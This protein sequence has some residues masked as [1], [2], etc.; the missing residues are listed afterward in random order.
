M[1]HTAIKIE[2]VSKLYRL[3]VY[4]ARTLREDFQRWWWKVKGKGDPLAKIDAT[5]TLESTDNKSYV[6]ALRDINID[7][8]QG[9]VLGIIGKNGAGKSTLLKILSRVTLPTEGAIKIKGRIGSLLEVG[10]GFHPELTGR[11]NIFLNGAILGMKRWEINRKFDDIVDFAGVAKYIDTPVKRYSSGMRVRLGFAVA[12]FLEPEILVV[13][14]VLAVGDAEFQKRAIG[15]MQ[16]VSRSDGRTVL[17]VSHNMGSIRKLCQRTVVLD[18][19]KVI[20]DGD[21]G[22]AIEKYLSYNIDKDINRAFIQWNED[23]APGNSKLKLLEIKIHDSKGKIRN[24]YT[25]DEDIFI[26]LKYRIKSK[27]SGY[28]F[29]IWLKTA[30]GEIAFISSSH[31]L[32]QHI[33]ETGDYAI[34]TKIPKNLLNTKQYIIALNC[35]I[36]GV[37]YIIKEE[38]F[39][40]ISIE[41]SGAHGST[42]TENWPG[43]VAPK[44][45]W[46]IIEK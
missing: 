17:F 15:K 16:D 33:S 37:E 2:N 4:G 29:N 7:V 45:N 46:E 5:N 42:Y 41:S 32:T 21:T 18:K 26:T 44:L 6:W 39:L 24:N 23:K 28:R 43:I 3:G 38:N 20:F 11:E 8:A 25:Q 9:E 31:N 34:Q 14:E 27:I 22:K 19:G 1:S 40:E 13:D 35:G 12:A 36:P 10:T 30:Y